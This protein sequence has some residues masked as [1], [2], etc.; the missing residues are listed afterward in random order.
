[1]GYD[2]LR[3]IFDNWHN[4]N[5]F[6]SLNF[7]YATSAPEY[8]EG[9]N[10]DKGLQNL[11]DHVNELKNLEELNLGLSCVGDVGINNLINH[12]DSL[13]KLK[14]LDFGSISIIILI[15]YY[16]FILI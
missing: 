9:F 1:M 11:L 15:L 4:I 2:G 10:G 6:T 16:S 7:G 14:I 5:D 8:V 12:F 3:Y 13:E